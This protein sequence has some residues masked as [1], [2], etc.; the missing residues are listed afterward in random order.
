MLDQMSLRGLR[1]AWI[2]VGRMG[3][4]MSRRLLA[5]GATLTVCDRDPARLAPLVEAGAMAG[6]IAAAARGCDITI[7]MVPDDAALEA[8][9]AQ[10]ASGAHPGLLHIDMSTVSPGASARVAAMLAPTGAAYLRAPVSGSTSTAAAGQLAFFL[11]GTADA[12]T[13]AAPVLDKLGTKRLH[14]GAAEEARAT[15]LLVN[16]IVAAMPALLGEAIGFGTRLGLDRGMVV[17]ALGQSVVASPLLAYKAEAMTAR[18]WTPAASVDLLA[19][20]LDLALEVARDAGLAPE[21][22]ALVRAAYAAAQARGEG[23][24]DFFRLTDPAG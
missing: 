10:V 15:K 4:P 20:D 13:R 21:I 18:D 8:V 3:E 16:M 24:L 19:K 23:G 5:A 6:E 12:V 1:I 22:V 11:S 9:A 14:V 2:G 7:S 17:Q